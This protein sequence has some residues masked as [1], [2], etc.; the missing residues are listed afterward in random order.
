M[1]ITVEECIKTILDKDASECESMNEE[2]FDCTLDKTMKTVMDESDKLYDKRF[3]I[4]ELM[5]DVFIESSPVA[6][7]DLLEAYR[8]SDEEERRIIAN[9]FE[10]IIGTPFTVFLK[11]CMKD[12]GFESEL[13]IE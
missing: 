11:R 6:T 9:F 8:D 2:Y 1:N 5:S 13:D 10:Y 12:M 3:K 7:T 4:L